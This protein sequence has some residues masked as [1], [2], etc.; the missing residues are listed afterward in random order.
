MKIAFLGPE[1]SY[2][3]LAA[4]SFL[5]TEAPKGERK[6]NDWDECIPFRNFA[7]VF[8]AYASIKKY[9]T[10]IAL[11]I[12][13]IL[14][15]LGVILGVLMASVFVLRIIDGDPN[16]VMTSVTALICFVVGAVSLFFIFRLAAL[17]AL[18]CDGYGLW[19]SAGLSFSITKNYL[20]EIFRSRKVVFVLSCPVIQAYRIN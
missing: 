6:V 13:S 15:T 19:K 17:V 9:L 11:S 14:L 3:H 18:V 8:S 7:E 4:Q 1:G 20:S 2:S 16:V 12:V 10:S 5:K